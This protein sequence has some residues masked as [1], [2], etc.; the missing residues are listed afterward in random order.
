[1][2]HKAIAVAFGVAVVLI[3]ALVVFA[4][5]CRAA[6]GVVTCW[7]WEE[8]LYWWVWASVALTLIFAVSQVALEAVCG[9]QD[10]GERGQ[11]DGET[12][13]ETAASGSGGTVSGN[14]GQAKEENRR[15]GWR[16]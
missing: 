15:A 9:P 16:D 12:M 7:R 4:F 11:D 13:D 3:L 5:V 10:D 6:G 8:G 1:M 2:I 14:V